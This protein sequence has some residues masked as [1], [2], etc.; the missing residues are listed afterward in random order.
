MAEAYYELM[1]KYRMNC[2]LLP[3][4]GAGGPDR[5]VEL[6]RKYYRHY[7]F[8]TYK[9][10]TEYKED[11]YDGEAI[12]FDAE[13]FIGY[14]VAIARASM[15]DKIDYLDK[16]LVYF[17]FSSGIDEPQTKENYEKCRRFS[18]VYGAFLRDIDARLK[19]E[20][21]SRPDY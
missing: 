17:T 8:S 12:D 18:K 4:S 13:A 14:I 9:L 10:P 2:E 1:L 21:S 3:F 7:G 11:S 19:T 5:Y 20:F 15:E 16:A 6:L